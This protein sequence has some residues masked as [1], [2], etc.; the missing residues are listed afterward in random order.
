VG[1]SGE[2]TSAA[3][4]GA[5]GASLAGVSGKSTALGG[6]GVRG[7]ANNG[8]GFG[9]WG[10]S[11]LGMGVTGVSSTG[12]GVAGYGKIGVLG[13][14]RETATESTD[15]GVSGSSE[16]FGTWGYLGGGYGAFG[17]HGSFEGYLGH[18]DGGVL[19]R[20]NTSGNY[21][22]LGT[23]NYAGMFNGPVKI[24]GLPP[25]AVCADQM[26]VLG[27]CTPSDA[28]L[29]TAVVDLR[30]ELD[31]AAVL[32]GLRGVAFNWDAS[33]ERAKDLG[34]RREI[35]LIAQEVEAVLPQVVSTGADGYKSVDYAK[36]TALLIEVTKSQQARID[37][38]ELR[39]AAVEAR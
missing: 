25:G 32:S 6:T 9:V 5:L 23:A 2:N 27:P 36:L 26:S 20:D 34:D 4:S 35:G 24:S 3:S 12:F 37:A 30:E 17:K 7:E 33:Q 22:Y 11:D 15:A 39:L 1:V 13:Q 21:G 8:Y 28:R 38:L 29:K 14:A 16:H 10:R 31:L 19:G 18:S